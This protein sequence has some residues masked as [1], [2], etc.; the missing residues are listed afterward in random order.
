MRRTLTLCRGGLTVAAALVL[1]TA[2]GG[3][4]EGSDKA[5]AASS[6]EPTA[7]SA[8]NTA[9]QADSEFCTQAKALSKTLDAAFNDEVSDPTSLAQQFQQTADAIRTLDPPA[10]IAADWEKLA[11]GLERFAGA[12]QDFDPNDPAAASTF[13]E[14]G[15][16]LQSEFVT[17]GEKV[18][19]YLSAECGIATDA[20]ES[21]SPTG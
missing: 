20:P 18:G 16:Q 4:S 21:A 14:L 9:P 2:C 1:L 6:S 12:F 8:E 5:A 19:T 10:E 15:A 3:S 13:A 17:S 7:S 11:A